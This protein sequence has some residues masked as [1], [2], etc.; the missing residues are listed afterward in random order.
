MSIKVMS[1]VWDSSA[2]EGYRLLVMLALA[3]HADDDGYCYPG[4]ARIAAKCRISE[5]TTRRCIAEM[6]E[7][8]EL[9]VDQNKGA[10]CNGGHT[11]RYRVIV[12]NRPQISA[13]V[14][15]GVSV[16]PPVTTVTPPSLSEPVK[17][18]VTALTPK[19]SVEP[20]GKPSAVSQA[21][22]SFLTKFIEMDTLDFAEAWDDWL[23][24]RKKRKLKPYAD[25]GL[26]TLEMLSK[27][28]PDRAIAAI[29][30]SRSQ[31]YQG[32]YEPREKRTGRDSN[33]NAGTYNEG[34]SKSWKGFE[35]TS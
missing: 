11:N 15:G 27:L 9:V 33:R 4:L 13:D 7:R 31:N 18:G 22:T 6:V 2:S 21:L 23:V 26:A 29:H 32:I 3:D 25:G 8:G 17:G 24:Y 16:T 30:H 28:G 12:H 19:P 5:S 14:Q 34:R 35:R 1:Q 10:A 20:S